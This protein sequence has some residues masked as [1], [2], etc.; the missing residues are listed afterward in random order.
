M[1]ASGVAVGAVRWRIPL[2]LLV[3]MLVNYLDRNTISL[4]LPKIAEEYGWTDRQIGSNGDLLLAA[5]FLAYG[6]AQMVL[7]PIAERGSLK[8]ALMIALVAFS[9]FTILKAPLGASLTA[10]IVLRLLLG[11]GEGVHVPMMSAITAR[12]FPKSERSRANSLWSV[13]AILATALGPLFVVPLISAI[14]WRDAFA[15][16]GGA[17]LLISLPLVWFFVADNPSA[18]RVSPAELEH[19]RAGQDQSLER[20]VPSS[21][22]SSSSPSSHATS[23]HTRNADYWLYVVAG[24]LNAF[25][26]F[27]FLSWLPTYFTRAK[28]INFEALG[29]PLALVFASGVVGTLL[30]AQLGDRSG[31]RLVLASAGFLVAGVCAFLA[32]ASSGVFA[33]VALFALAVFGQGAFNAQEYATVQRLVSANRVGSGT[34]LYNGLSV[35]FGGVGGSLIPG[36]ILA[37]T[38]DYGAALTSIAVGAL[39]ASAMMWLLSRRLR[40]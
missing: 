20:S 38:G 5:F 21:L 30:W 14:G 40:Y 25:C 22:V 3:T 35:I 39:L 28:N 37:A 4:A 10:L 36:G 9:V 16:L 19:I 23:S 13:G 8:R 24:I 27:G 6:I 17:G 2:A 32:L 18:P 11:I 26:A 1:T 29:W 7:T 12:W 33:L 31:R 15:V 34:G